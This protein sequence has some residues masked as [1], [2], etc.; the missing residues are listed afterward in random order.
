MCVSPKQAS[1][2]LFLVFLGWNF[3]LS[4]APAGAQPA[5]EEIQTR[6]G[7]IETRLKTIE[8]RQQEIIERED[9][10]LAE[11]DRLRIWVRRQ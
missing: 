7:A 10:I 9:R 11:L 1:L 6:L 8:A 5:G 2:S 3:F 4:P